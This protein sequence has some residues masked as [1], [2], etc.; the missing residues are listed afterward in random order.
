[1]IIINIAKSCVI[2]YVSIEEMGY[3]SW[4]WSYTWHSILASLWKL[5]ISFLQKKLI[6]IVD[7]YVS[8]YVPIRSMNYDS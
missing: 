8:I 3:D 4:Q 5:I 1:M 6:F 7:K 2:I